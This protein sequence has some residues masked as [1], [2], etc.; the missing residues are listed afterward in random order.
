MNRRSQRGYVDTAV[1]L[2]CLKIGRDGCVRVRREAK[3]NSDEYEKAGATM[4]AIDGLA[5]QLTGDPELFWIKMH[6]ADVGGG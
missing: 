3:I 5:E 2:E 4:K 6:R 1:V